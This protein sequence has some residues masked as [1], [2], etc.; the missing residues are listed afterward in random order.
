MARLLKLPKTTKN[1]KDSSF[2]MKS[3]GFSA[4]HFNGNDFSPEVMDSVVIQPYDAAANFVVG[5]EDP[6]GSPS[7]S[8][9]INDPQSTIPCESTK[10]SVTKNLTIY[11]GTTAADGS[12]ALLFMGST[13][14]SMYEPATVSAAHA[15]TW[16]G[17]TSTSTDGSYNAGYY[18]RPV[19]IYARLRVVQTGDPHVVTGYSVRVL[20]ATSPTMYGTCPTATNIGITQAQRDWLFGTEATLPVDATVDI[21]L[22]CS[23]GTT[24]YY[25]W[26]QVGSERAADGFAGSCFWLYGLRSTDRVEVMVGSHAE[27]LPVSTAAA[28]LSL[29]NFGAVQ[30][31]SSASEVATATAE[32]TTSAGRDLTVNTPNQ[33][34]SNAL[35]SGTKA[36]LS[37]VKKAASSDFVDNSINAITNIVDGNWWSAAKDVWG[38][39]SGLFSSKL[40]MS[41]F[42]KDI[43]IQTPDGPLRLPA[44]IHRYAPEA[45][46]PQFREVV[47]QLSSTR[48]EPYYPQLGVL[49][50]LDGMERG[51][52]MRQRALA[53][54]R[55]GKTVDEAKEQLQQQNLFRN[56]LSSSSSA[57]PDG[58][59]LDLSTPRGVLAPVPRAG[60]RS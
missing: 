50:T 13:Y 47:T 2:G 24:S 34:P 22:H 20:P 43:T 41:V 42:L 32:A 54:P 51:V 48:F 25:S 33:T 1:A 56:S 6:W 21:R 31:A 45:F 15:I 12:L 46:P 37:Q 39:V 27:Y 18:N 4:N 44:V 40:A 26:T 30:S 60:L 19:I 9:R 38:A 11:N 55:L 3:L 35:A 14:H 8:L 59:G 49:W 16:V 53:V 36:V 23:R 57:G 7:G 5:L 29:G 52:A 17:G 10:N 58:R 28:P